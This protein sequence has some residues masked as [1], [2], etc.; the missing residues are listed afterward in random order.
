MRAFIGVFPIAVDCVLAQNMQCAARRPSI[1]SALKEV[2]EN[3]KH[4][5]VMGGLA[6]LTNGLIEGVFLK[7]FNI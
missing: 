4:T 1:A 6:K 7:I 5:L 3:L 2:E